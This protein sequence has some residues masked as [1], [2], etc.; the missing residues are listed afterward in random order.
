[1]KVMTEPIEIILILQE[2]T[3]VSMDPLVIATSIVG[4]IC[5]L[6]ILKIW[7]KYKKKIS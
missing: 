6:E 7:N 4:S 1:M 3:V 2:Q 5:T